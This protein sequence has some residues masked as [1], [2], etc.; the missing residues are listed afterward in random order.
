MHEVHATREIAAP[1]SVIW[2]VLDDFG[3]VS[4]FNPA[5][6]SARIVGGPQTGEGAIRE[7]VLEEGGIIRERIVKYEPESSLTI[8]FEDLGDMDRFVSDFVTVWAVESLEDTRSEVTLTGRYTPKFG[9]VGWLMAKFMM[10][11]KLTEIY[12]E[13]LQSLDDYI[14][15][16]P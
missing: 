12:H 7:C 8:E 1:R 6:T 9:P 15:A 5:V 3:G 13:A 14:E 10:N 4:K 11:S 16:N 2:A